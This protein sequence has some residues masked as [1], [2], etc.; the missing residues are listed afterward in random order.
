VLGISGC[1]VYTFNPSGKSDIKTIAVEPFENRT[2][3][4]GLADRLTDV[5]IDAF[6]ADGTVKVVPLTGA[7]AVLEAVLTN[8]ERVVSQFDESDQVQT[9][10]VV[11]NFEVTLRNPR[12]NSE[13]WKEQMRQ[14]GIYDANTQTEEYGQ[15]AAG[16]QLVDAILTKTT[17]SW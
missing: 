10:K 12:D 15:N 16:A 3:E 14:E 8:Y 2:S 11:M 1:G 6:I 17:K 4:Y 9:Y 7:D 13:F 5:V